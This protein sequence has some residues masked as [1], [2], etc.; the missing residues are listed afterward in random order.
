MTAGT[1][2][3]ALRDAMRAEIPGLPVWPWL[4]DATHAEPTPG[5]A[6]ILD[7]IE[8][9]SS[10]IAKP[11]AVG[12]HHD[13]YGHDHLRFDPL[14]GQE[15]FRDEINRIFRRNGVVYRLMDNHQVQRP[16]EPVVQKTFESV[17]FDTGDAELNRM[18]HTALSKFQHRD[19]AIRR[20]ALELAWDAWERLK[21]LSPGQ[22]KRAQATA[23]LDDAAGSSAP[24]Y[25]LLLQNEAKELTR[26]GNAMQIRHFETDQERL[27][28]TEHLDYVFYR[29]WVFLSMLLRR[30]GRLAV[31]RD[32]P[33]AEPQVSSANAG[34]QTASGDYE[35]DDIPF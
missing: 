27:G 8:F 26:I 32:A 24:K 15:E 28:L 31:T 19:P 21:T 20:E 11:R 3:N 14:Q 1:D 30:T 7:M 29:M 10:K 16:S 13:F 9:C 23:L 17:S 12:R 35:H 22:N 34:A 2:D 5:T 18:L 25:L 33:T 4:N 6:S